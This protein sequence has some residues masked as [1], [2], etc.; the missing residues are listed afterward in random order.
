CHVRN[1]AGVE[2]DEWGTYWGGR[3][4]NLAVN[5]GYYEQ[6]LDGVLAGRQATGLPD[7]AGILTIEEQRGGIVNHALHLVIPEANATY[8]AH[9]ARRTDGAFTRA[10]AIPEGTVFRLPVK[11]NLDAIDMDPY[12]RMIAKA[13]QKYGLYISDTGGAVVFRAENPAGRYA[14]D[15][16][17]GPGGILRCPKHGDEAPQECWPTSAG[18][19]LRGFP[20]DKLQ[21]LAFSP[22][23]SPNFSLHPTDRVQ[24]QNGP[25]NVRD[26]AHGKFL[27]TQ[28]KGAR[29]T[30]VDGLMS[31]GHW[32]FNINFD[33]GPDGWVLEDEIK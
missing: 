31:G 24:A 19:R 33:A 21:A 11:L 12:A 6:R 4:D 10:D 27:G 32:W 25:V 5:P 3:V 23:V 14:I 26:S 22:P 30:V 29:G 2:V 8:F 7:L 9:P 16:Y 15:P 28:P 20:W 18:G 17:Y 13:V 1:S